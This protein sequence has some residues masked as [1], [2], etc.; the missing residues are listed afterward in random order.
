[1]GK[2]GV[3]LVALASS[4]GMRKAATATAAAVSIS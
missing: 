1:M 2:N 4:D 3:I